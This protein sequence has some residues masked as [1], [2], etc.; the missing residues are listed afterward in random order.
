MVDVT[1]PC[2]TNRLMALLL[3]QLASVF[4]LKKNV[5]QFFFVTKRNKGWQHFRCAQASFLLFCVSSSF[6]GFLNENIFHSIINQ[7]KSG[8]GTC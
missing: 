3:H 7:I 8:V 5:K 2:V 1:F 4:S 6:C